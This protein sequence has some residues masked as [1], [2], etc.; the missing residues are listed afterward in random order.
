MLLVSEHFQPVVGCAVI[1]QFDRSSD[2][3][4]TP[5][6]PIRSTVD[7]RSGHSALITR[8][9]ALL[10]MFNSPF[11]TYPYLQSIPPPPNQPNNQIIITTS[12]QW[13]V[14]QTCAVLRRM[15]HQLVET[16]GILCAN[17]ISQLMM[18]I[19]FQ[20][21]WKFSAKYM[22]QWIVSTTW[23][24]NREIIFCFYSQFA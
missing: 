15:C 17:K 2:D 9:S 5:N 8:P 21:Q 24:I 3:K 12:R 22:H 16:I 19:N 13:F 14:C 11:N 1:R 18:E 6:V 23:I 7:S 10:A 4:C 20:R